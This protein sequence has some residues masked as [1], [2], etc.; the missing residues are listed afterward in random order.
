MC[1]SLHAVWVWGGGIE[2]EREEAG[3]WDKKYTVEIYRIFTVTGLIFGKQSN[4]P[5]GQRP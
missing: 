5:P 4:T 1:I 2:G 3:A